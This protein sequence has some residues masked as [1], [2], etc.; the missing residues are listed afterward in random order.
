[1]QKIELVQSRQT[2]SAQMAE[3]CCNI[4]GITDS[5]HDPTQF[6]AAEN[7]C[8]AGGNTRGNLA[9]SSE[10]GGETETFCCRRL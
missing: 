8:L 3:T 1:M 7:R 10:D 6:D 9:P 4:S 5:H 2:G